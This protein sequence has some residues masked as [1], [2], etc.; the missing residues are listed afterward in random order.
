VLIRVEPPRQAAP[1]LVGDREPTGVHAPIAADPGIAD[2]P[3]FFFSKSGSA[4]TPGSDS[5]MWPPPQTRRSSS[6]RSCQ[7]LP[8]SS[9]PIAQVNTYSHHPP[10]AWPLRYELAKSPLAVAFPQLSHPGLSNSS[11]G[12]IRAVIKR[13]AE[14]VIWPLFGSSGWIIRLAQ[15]RT[16]WSSELAQ[17]DNSAAPGISGERCPGDSRIPSCFSSWVSRPALRSKPP[18]TYL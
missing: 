14:G 4:P 6:G 16:S 13:A 17:L 5:I 10:H 9:I 7:L 1:P 12:L 11:L 2:D 3:A 18:R 8:K 15:E